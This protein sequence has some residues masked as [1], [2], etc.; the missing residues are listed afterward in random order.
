MTH[1]STS[2]TV[3]GQQCS[4]KF[5]TVLSNRPF[6]GQFKTPAHSPEQPSV[7]NTPVMEIVVHPPTT[8]VTPKTVTGAKQVT[9]S[10]EKDKTKLTSVPTQFEVSRTPNHQLYTVRQGIGGLMVV[11]SSAN[12]CY[13]HSELKIFV[14]YVTFTPNVI[15]ALLLASRAHQYMLQTLLVLVTAFLLDCHHLP[16]MQHQFLVI[17]LMTRC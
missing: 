1:K 9:A 15:Q 10:L 14:K 5:V 4:E 11:P 13:K 12:P 6:G 7:V 17:Y 2:P 16:V 3:F 8:N